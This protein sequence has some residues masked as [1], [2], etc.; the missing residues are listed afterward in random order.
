LA[1][2]LTLSPAWT[3]EKDRVEADIENI[4]LKTDSG[5]NA[6]MVG[7]FE[8]YGEFVISTARFSEWRSYDW[9]EKKRPVY[10]NAVFAVPSGTKSAELSFGGKV[11]KLEVPAGPAD[12]PNPADLVKVEILESGYT[13]EI[14]GEHS[15]GDLEPKPVTVTTGGENLLLA[16]RLRLTPTKANG[17]HPDQFFWYTPWF[18]VATDSGLYVPTMGEIFFDRLNDNVS[19]NLDRSSDGVFTSAEATLYF[20]APQ[21]MSAFKLTYMALP[22]AEGRLN[23]PAPK[24]DQ[25]APAAGKD[26]TG[27]EKA[28]QMIKG[29]FDK[30][31]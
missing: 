24:A 5:E 12:P 13:D 23:P 17:N 15:V 4:V 28:K 21:G 11:V 22:V 10:W 3:E 26:A 1:V 7:Y 20:A 16:V 25:E 27:Q 6:P 14:R 2:R 29:L 8:R 18:G 31:Q 9:Q 19:H 30:T